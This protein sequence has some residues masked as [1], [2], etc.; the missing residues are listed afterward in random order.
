MS[1]P[2][3][4]RPPSHPPLRRRRGRGWIVLAAIVAGVIV[5]AQVVAILQ[6]RIPRSGSRHATLYYAAATDLSPGAWIGIG[7]LEERLRAVGYRAGEDPLEPGQYR[8]RGETATIHLLPFRYPDVD[9]PGGI[10]RLR[11]SRGSVAESEL[12]GDDDP[13]LLRL[14]PERIAGYTGQTGAILDPL[15]LEEA[16]PL[17]VEAL[18]SVED[19]RFYRHPGVD[20]IGTVRAIWADLRHR[21]AA[22]GGST[23]TQQLARS[24]FL[25][26]RKTILRKVQEA[27]LAVGLEIRYSKRQILEAYLN[28]VYWGT[29]GP[30]EIRGAREASRYYLGCELEDADP[31]GLALLVG[32][33]KAP[34][35][36]SP[37]SSPERAKKRRDLVLKVLSQKGVLDEREVRTALARPLPSTKPPKRLVD[38][39]YFLDAAR[40][41]IERRAPRGTL[42]RTGLAVFTT[43]DPRQQSAAEQSL[44]DGLARLEKDHRKLR[45]KNSPLQG[46]VVTIDPEN[47]EVRAL[48]GGRDFLRWPFNRALD[49]NRQAGSAFKPFV[50]LAAFQH[51]K[52]KGGGFWTASSILRDEPLSIRSG[53]KTWNVHNYDRAYRGEVSL[54]DALEQSLNVPTAALGRDVGIPKVAEAARAMGITSKLDEVPSLTIGT[55]GVSLMEITAAYAGFAALGKPHRPHCLRGLVGSNGKPIDLEP[56]VDPPGVEPKEAYM[57]TRLLRGVIDSEHGTGR[58]ARSMGVRGSVAGKTG[59]TDDYRDAWF[60][61]FTPRRAIGVWVGFDRREL[62]GLSGTAAALPIWA[63]AMRESIDPSGDGLF[64]RPGGIVTVPICPETGLLAT[65]SCPDFREEEY[66]EGTEPLDSCDRHGGGIIGTIRRFLNL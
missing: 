21:E 45:K 1:V 55:S 38:A 23:L 43:L 7:E 30:M 52:R 44:A 5:V 8:L 26:N 27:F 40:K 65:G 39:A 66:I 35:A 14:D 58:S 47:G 41:E 42:D 6:A 60:V 24:L 51:P 34:N 12:E 54:R 29:W 31:A 53:R 10:L 63:S 59:T 22:Q 37:Y 2:E 19:R 16:P 25:H 50:Y 32:L 57:I 64:P 62:I 3:P 33:L 4:P 9:S 11:I 18:V 13:A 46:A 20:P 49:P 28:A 56:L 17:L 61:G 36:Y 48:V 15:R